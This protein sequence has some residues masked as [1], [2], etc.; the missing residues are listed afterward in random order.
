MLVAA[1]VP[2]MWLFNGIEFERVDAFMR[3]MFQHLNNTGNVEKSIVTVDI[4]SKHEVFSRPLTFEALKTVIDKILANKPKNLIV[5]LSPLELYLNEEKKNS[6][7]QKLFD[8]LIT[9]PNVYLYS[10]ASGNDHDVLKDKILSK[11]PRIFWYYMIS[12]KSFGPRDNKRRKAIIW[13]DKEGLPAEFNNIRALG[14]KI[15]DPEYF[16]Y[17]WHFWGSRQA[18]IKTYPEGTFGSLDADRM[19]KQKDS[20]LDFENKTVILGTNDEYSFLTSIS[21][22]NLSGKIGDPGFKAYSVGDSLANYISMHV[23]GDYM[24]L[25]QNF[26]D[27][28]VVFIIL[29]LI[30]F[31]KLNIRTKIY[32]FA[33]LIPIIV[34]CLAL[35]YASTSFYINCSRSLTL[36]FFIQYLI[37]PVIMLN[38]FKEQESK[39]LQEISDARIDALLTISEKVAHDIRSPLSAINLVA[40]KAIFPNSEY[41][42]IFDSAVT[43]IDETAA[44]ILTRYRTKTGSENEITEP[45][46]VAEVIS[47]IIREKKALNP[48]VDFEFV[49]S[50]EITLALGLRLDLERIVSNIIDNSIFA[51]KQI[52]QPKVFISI[53]S[54][55]NFIRMSIADNGVGIPEQ[56]LKL[57]GT[58]RITTKADTGQGNGIGLLHAKR[59]IERLNGR[60]EISSLE[61]IGTTIRISLPKA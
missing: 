21:I 2:V 40:T 52:L 45:I 60:F 37:F 47:T 8:Y 38:T 6:E 18:F 56:I 29:T 3:D 57:L 28:A 23:T 13:Y 44:K 32:I 9:K 22:F 34:F 12:D 33:S 17:A 42:E 4:N 50:T 24:K 5:A 10:S 15:K 11:F 58:A 35:L 14:F 59:V 41:K 55:D 30:T 16:K 51:L 20:E 1:L 48:K 25:L 31:L 7:K 39:K 46:D 27:L 53:E 61:N 19:L 26:N 49:I 43:R 36:L 54:E